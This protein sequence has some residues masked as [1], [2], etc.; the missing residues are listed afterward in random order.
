MTVI[1]VKGFKI[2]RDKKPPFKTRCYHRAT[3]H[4]IDLETVAL[5]S[6]A[7]FAECAKITAL[8][9]AQKIKA[10]TAGT[11]GGLIMAYYRTEHFSDTLSD[12]TR[13]YYRTV[14][15]YLEPILDTPIAA[16]DTPLAS[17]IHDRATIKLGWL[18]RICCARS[19]SKCL[20]MGYPRA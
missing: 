19:F 3:G 12:R 8:V 4:K 10:P 1:K 17:G 9:E 14:A 6:A 5:G 7:F 15:K 16:I 13:K 2:F 18:R 11:L 20:S